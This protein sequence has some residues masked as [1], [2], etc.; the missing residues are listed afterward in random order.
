MEN[1]RR[2]VMFTIQYPTVWEMYKR[3][4]ASSWTAEEVGLSHDNNDWGS[5]TDNE[6]HSVKHVLTFF[7]A[8]DGIVLERL[9]GMFPT[10]IQ[11]PEAF[12]A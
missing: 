7:A 9:A 10:Q 2:F 8:S 3:H 12:K 11:I 4:E 1:P 5:L 6:R